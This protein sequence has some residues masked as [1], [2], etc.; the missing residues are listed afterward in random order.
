MK[1]FL[2]TRAE[3]ERRL[4]A[5]KYHEKA[6]AG[7]DAVGLCPIVEL[8]EICEAAKKLKAKLEI[9]QFRSGLQTL[10]RGSIS[11]GEIVVINL[12]QSCLTHSLFERDEENVI[13]LWSDVANTQISPSHSIRRLI[14]RPSNQ[15]WWDS[16]IY[17]ESEAIYTTGE[18]GDNG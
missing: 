5:A 12:D 18:S 7:V 13:D 10:S 11:L 14:L 3:I 17:A 16:D 4:V 6:K 8:F 2:L 1:T 9:D 15:T